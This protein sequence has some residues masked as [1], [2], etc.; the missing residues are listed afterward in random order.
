MTK[1]NPRL[2]GTGIK[3]GK[4]PCYGIWRK[5]G[6]PKL[7]Q[8][9]R[10]KMGRAPWWAEDEV[11]DLED[12][13]WWPCKGAKGSSRRT[14]G[15]YVESIIDG[16]KVTQ[17]ESNNK[18][19]RG[20]LRGK[21]VLIKWGKNSGEENSPRRKAFIAKVVKWGKKQFAKRKSPPAKPTTPKKTANAKTETYSKE[22]GFILVGYLDRPAKKGF[23]FPQG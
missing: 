14:T 18:R 16:I 13:G 8:A 6:R 10:R 5:K 7:T 22:T 20:H 15:P 17:V 12:L 21:G 4:H 11:Q 9:Q 1:R 2:A 19:S 3:H 23:F